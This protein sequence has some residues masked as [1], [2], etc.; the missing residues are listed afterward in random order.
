VPGATVRI[1]QLG[2]EAVTDEDGYYFVPGPPVAGPRLLTFEFSAPGFGPL[3]IKNELCEPSWSSGCGYSP[4]LE[5]GDTAIVRDYCAFESPPF[6][7]GQGLHAGLC[8]E[9]G[10]APNYLM[11]GC[12]L[13]ERHQSG[14][15]VAAIVGSVVDAVSGRPI[16]G[17]TVTIEE[18]REARVTGEDG[19]FLFDPLP[20]PMPEPRT[21]SG[22][23]VTLEVTAPG[24][25]TLTLEHFWLDVSHALDVKLEAG[26][27][28]QTVDRC[29][30]SSLPRLG[31][32]L[33][34]AQACRQ[35]GILIVTDP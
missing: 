6:S 16:A 19:C 26:T 20:L 29:I 13:P 17:A 27:E 28:P 5:R 21:L 30:F 11:L 32:G 9:A 31:L 22:R 33:G 8:V 34:Q 14:P 1:P 7:A 24:Y 35:A 15:P 12:P 2:L 25:R 18:Y 10:V 3:V 23:F 4:M